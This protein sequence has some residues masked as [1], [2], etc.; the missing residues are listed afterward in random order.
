MCKHF[1]Y[2]R[3]TPDLTLEEVLRV[4][5]LETKKNSFVRSLLCN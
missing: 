1:D 3:I 5:H 2:F 4:I